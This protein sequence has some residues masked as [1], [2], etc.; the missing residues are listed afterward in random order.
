MARIPTAAD[1]GRV[2]SRSGRGTARQNTTAEGLGVVSI[3]RG[4]QDLGQGVQ[5]FAE[6]MQ[7]R[8][9]TLDIAKAELAKNEG[10]LSLTNSF[11]QD[12]E[13]A[14]YDERAT[15]GVQQTVDEA[16]AL[17]RDPQ[18]RELWKVR[19]LN[20]AATT[21]D[22][23]RD[24]GVDLQIQADITAFDEVLEANRR[25]YVAPETPESMR[26]R[27]R[28]DIEGSIAVA[29]A[30]GLLTPPQAAARRETYL[31][32]ADYSRGLLAVENGQFEG[33]LPVI[34][35]DD[36]DEATA[37]L[38]RQFEGFRQ[39]PY[40]D[41]NAHRVGYGSDT[42]TRADGSVIRV[43]ANM[44]T[45]REDAERDLAR[46]IDDFQNVAAGQVG[47]SKW[48][49]LPTNVKAALGSVTY[50]Y[51]SLPDPVVDAVKTGDTER[52][53]QAVASLQTDNDGINR[54]RRLKEAA[55]IRGQ[56]NPDWY[57]R[58]SPEQQATVQKQ[59]EQVR[60]TSDAETRARIEMAAQDA[61]AAIASTGAYTG[62][63]P[64]QEDFL[65]AYG[66]IEAPQAH[67]EYQAAVA[68]SRE[69]YS[70]RTMSNAEIAEAVQ[71][72]RPTA[73]GQGAAAESDRYAIL[74]KAA[75]QVLTAREEDPVAY[76]Q[77]MFPNVRAAWEG[78]EDQAGYRQAIELTQAAQAQLGI[79]M[80]PVLPQSV[81]ETVATQFT[82]AELPE[83][84]RIGALT[85]A[86]FATDDPAQRR[87][88]YQ[89][90]VDE[91]VPA[92]AEA[93][94]VALERGD[95]G[96]ARRLFH[97][98]MINPADLPGKVPE[99]PQ[100]IAEEIQARLMAPGAIGDIYYGLSG[101]QVENFDRAAT[102]AKLIQNAVSLR[103]LRGDSLSEAIDSTAKDIFGDVRVVNGN[104]QVGA[105]VLLPTDQNPEPY[106]R[107]FSGLKEQ[108]REALAFPIP[109]DV[110]SADG[111]RAIIEA[112]TAAYIENVMAEG[113]FTNEGNGYSFIDPFA[114]LPVTGADGRPLIFT[115]A[116][117]L[118]VAGTVPESEVPTRDQAEDWLRQSGVF[119]FEGAQ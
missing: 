5:A 27:V 97:A 55:I 73:T 12:T 30:N 103:L 69:A 42:I 68:T 36:A 85:Q 83:T 1:L 44:A 6:S 91:G 25:I 76:V 98:A 16:A 15:A 116:D 67:A 37:G 80:G 119:Q 32:D 57:A 33:A 41:V 46:R 110:E 106:L 38:L 18:A 96:A 94:I 108:V 22:T 9:T 113:Y 90:L 63:T 31:D 19:A 72:A 61:P 4:I 8:R 115:D 71:E 7:K 64:T 20:D 50:N 75:D 28:A 87:A 17:I 54:E 101:G 82:N 77:Q 107:G 104:W 60:N 84:E 65:A 111:A 92:M 34:A 21:A 24:R 95:A 52:I 89:Q 70:F 81:A 118:A 10:F 2:S 78:A 58:L 117:V 39:T 112:G 93:A 23:I 13:Y 100:R 29:E 105:R 109:D 11:D 53:A 26:Q 49:A 43:S 45:T 59:A 102:D 79:P 62:Y 88:I 40:W 48:E 51:G 47:Q 66:P 114:G 74:T 3:G 35:S 86:V 99:T 14:T 56:G